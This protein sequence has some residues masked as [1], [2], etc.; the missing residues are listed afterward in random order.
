MWRRRWHGNAIR[1]G[2]ARSVSIGGS[3]ACGLGFN[4]SVTLRISGSISFARG[5]GRSLTISFGR[6]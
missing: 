5:I 2:I 1:R 4:G 6:R 3:I